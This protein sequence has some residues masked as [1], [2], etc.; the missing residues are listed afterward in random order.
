V[1][2]NATETH[3]DGTNHLSP[4]VALAFMRVFCAPNGFAEPASF[5]ESQYVDMQTSEQ[6]IES[7][8]GSSNNRDLQSN[9]EWKNNLKTQVPKKRAPDRPAGEMLSKPAQVFLVVVFNIIGIKPKLP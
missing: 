1:A 4:N 6:R 9:L 3:I 8:E 5:L 7:A 2:T